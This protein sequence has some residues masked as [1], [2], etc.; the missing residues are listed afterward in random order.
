[1]LQSWIIGTV[2]CCTRHFRAVIA[3]G[4]LLAIASASYTAR[5]F[6]IDTDINDLLSA[7]LPWRQQEIAF[8]EAFPQTVDLILIDVG[9]ATPEAAEAAARELQQALPT[10]RNSFIP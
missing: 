2:D 8:H 10:N 6:A 5:H 7:K 1:M 9:A 4:L 3:G